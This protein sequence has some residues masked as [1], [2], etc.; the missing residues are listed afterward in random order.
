MA[1]SITRTVLHSTCGMRFP[2]Q[3]ESRCVLLHAAARERERER[4][5]P[6]AR[7]RV[8]VQ[9]QRG[10]AKLNGVYARAE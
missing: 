10:I 3:R 8:L 9:R 6:N 7:E 1:F 4:S 2:A 5:I